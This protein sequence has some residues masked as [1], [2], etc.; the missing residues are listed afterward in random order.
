[1]MSSSAHRGFTIV[2]LLIVIVDIAI[3]SVIATASYSYL[4][5]Q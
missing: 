1:M 3:L 5:A 4:L 2:G